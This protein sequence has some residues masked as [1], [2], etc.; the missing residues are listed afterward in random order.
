MGV[1]VTITSAVLVPVLA[2]VFIPARRR[3]VPWGERL[4]GEG[5]LP[6]N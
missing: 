3:P 1:S 2:S 4:A 6:L 5:E